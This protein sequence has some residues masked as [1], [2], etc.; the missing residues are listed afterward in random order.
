MENSPGEPS[1]HGVDEQVRASAIPTP[2]PPEDRLSENSDLVHGVLSAEGT[3]VVPFEDVVADVSAAGNPLDRDHGLA[4][5]DDPSAPRARVDSQFRT[6]SLREP[7]TTAMPDWILISASA[8]PRVAFPGSL[9]FRASGP[10]K[11]LRSCT[12][13]AG[14]SLPEGSQTVPGEFVEYPTGGTDPKPEMTVP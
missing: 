13:S 11:P 10:T 9:T 3:V 8:V 1:S 2:T 12:R 5:G 7:R 14:G 6:A 4:S